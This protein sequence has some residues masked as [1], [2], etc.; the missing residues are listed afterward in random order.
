MESKYKQIS[1][2]R[3]ESAKMAK[4]KGYGRGYGYGYGNGVGNDDGWLAI[5]LL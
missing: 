5:G 3:G 4:T 1:G 2:Q